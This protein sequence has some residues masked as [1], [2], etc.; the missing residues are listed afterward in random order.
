[1]AVNMSKPLSD[2]ERLELYEKLKSSEEFRPEDYLNSS[3]EFKVADQPPEVPKNDD[4]P[5]EVR[6]FGRSVV[7]FP[8]QLV[9]VLRKYGN[10]GK[11]LGQG[12]YGVVAELICSN[13]ETRLVVKVIFDDRENWRLEREYA[14]KIRHPNSISWIAEGTL[15]V[16]GRTV[17]WFVYP[18][19]DMSGEDLLEELNEGKATPLQRWA[20]AKTMVLQLLR[21]VEILHD[22]GVVHNDIFLR[23]ILVNRPKRK[24][25]RYTFFL[26]DYG[27]IRTR[28]ELI[29]SYH[30]PNREDVDY[31]FNAAA[32]LARGYHV[33]MFHF[34]INMSKM[35][36]WMEEC[37]ALL[38]RL[39]QGARVPFARLMQLARNSEGRDIVMTDHEAIKAKLFEAIELVEK[40]RTV[41]SMELGSASRGSEKLILASKESM[42]DSYKDGTVLLTEQH[43]R[44]MAVLYI[45]DNEEEGAEAWV[46][47]MPIHRENIAHR[48][49]TLA[50]QLMLNTPM[51][52]LSAVKQC[53]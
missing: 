6:Q 25:G 32:N 34:R 53:G 9:R 42:V 2:S 44:V 15:T 29:E 8:F 50:L 10:I 31:L 48:G 23:N 11:I 7:V 17:D 43:P 19:A 26:N 52:I 21:V 38:K 47:F 1:M 13:P 45:L 28:K 24:G 14:H 51:S 39:P 27:A 30:S 49:A 46:S 36:Q 35:P 4:H 18:R 33:D 22:L 3:G 20:I 41:L 16:D 40:E 5:P 37:R 12:V